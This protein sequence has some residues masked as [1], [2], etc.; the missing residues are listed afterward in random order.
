MP[1]ACYVAATRPCIWYKIY[2]RAFSM[3]REEL[4][5]EVLP[6]VDWDQVGTETWA[7]DLKQV[8]TIGIQLFLRAIL[9]SDL[10]QRKV[11]WHSVFQPIRQP[12]WWRGDDQYH[13]P[14]YKEPVSEL[15]RQ[16]K[17]GKFVLAAEITP[18]GYRHKQV[19][20]KYIIA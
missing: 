1:D 6:P 19:A 14:A 16:L 12:A 3:G 7:T 2:E 11:T 5:M 20:S 13:P 18:G 10:D 9:S 4:L 17:E 8:R 15:E